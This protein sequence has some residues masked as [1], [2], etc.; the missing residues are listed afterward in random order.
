M[1]RIIGIVLCLGV[2]AVIALVYKKMDVDVTQ[3]SINLI[4][5][6]TNAAGQI[7]DYNGEIGV[8]RPEDITVAFNEGEIIFLCYPST[9]KILSE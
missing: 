4:R 5:E 9:I 2:V 7:I 8:S 1:K 3:Q 6:H